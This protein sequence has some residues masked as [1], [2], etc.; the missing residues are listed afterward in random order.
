MAL[1]DHVPLTEF[2]YRA[3]ESADQD[4][5][6]RMC[7]LILIYTFRNK[8]ATGGN[9]RIRNKR[10]VFSFYAVYPNKNI[11]TYNPFTTI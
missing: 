5:T 2:M 7:R 11:Y 6:A 3:T 8:K 4:Q 1:P 10:Q 9:G